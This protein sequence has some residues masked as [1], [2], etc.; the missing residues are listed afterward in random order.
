MNGTEKLREFIESKQNLFFIVEYTIWPKGYIR[1]QKM[2]SQS[3]KLKLIF[4]LVILKCFCLIYFN[5]YNLFAMSNIFHGGCLLLSL[6][7]LIVYSKIILSSKYHQYYNDNIKYNFILI[8]GD[9]L[10][11]M[12]PIW[13]FHYIFWI[14]CCSPSE[15]FWIYLVYM[16]R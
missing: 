11:I 7:G 2:K 12:T 13:N 14:G 10:L 9:I 3:K 5:F 8:S 1:F 4:F 6:N 16:A 15:K